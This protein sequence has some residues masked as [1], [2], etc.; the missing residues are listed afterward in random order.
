[1]NPTVLVAYA[2]R[3]GST[4]EVAQAVAQDLKARGYAAV[5]CAVDKV[6]KLSAYQAVVL[7][8]SV[9]FGRWLPEAVGFVRRL[10]AELK[11][12]PT[13]FFTVHM[14]NLG[15]DA[16]SRKNRLAYI[17]PVRAMVRPGA[18]AFFAGKLDTRR[19]SLGARMLCKLMNTA[20]QDLRD[21]SAIHA[22]AQG[23]VLSRTK[24]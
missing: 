2:T 17:D 23:I 5:V 22:W 3:C 24:S 16:A 7:G 1:M 18:E 11:R 9:R 19:L 10:Q 4:L 13:A 14:Q 12:L 6:G 15:A 21:W 20:N 8:S